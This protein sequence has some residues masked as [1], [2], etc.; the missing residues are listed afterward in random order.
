MQDDKTTIAEM[1]KIMKEFM[2]ERG[3]QQFHNPKDLAIATAIEAA[4]IAGL[5]GIPV[6]VRTSMNK[7][8]SPCKVIDI[9]TRGYLN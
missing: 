1:K 7:Q 9:N 4:E 5:N 6:I 8:V 3:W 2:M